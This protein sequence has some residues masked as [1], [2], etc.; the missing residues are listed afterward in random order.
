MGKAE[1]PKELEN[2]D[3]TVQD[4]K[5]CHN[6]GRVNVRITKKMSLEVFN[7]NAAT[8]PDTYWKEAGVNGGIIYRHHREHSEGRCRYSC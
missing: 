3:I 8:D 1:K 6:C 7:Q 4:E 2:Q 5:S